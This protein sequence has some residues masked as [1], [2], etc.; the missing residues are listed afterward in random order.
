[1]EDDGK[2]DLTPVLSG[3]RGGRGSKC[4]NKKE[5][6]GRSMIR[7]RKSGV[8]L[9]CPQSYFPQCGEKN[10]EPRKVGKG[11]FCLSI[12]KK[13]RKIMSERGSAS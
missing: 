9:P 13:Q 2:V 3:A 12:T 7:R 5:W 1:L 11:I 4:P 8:N 10:Q 6:L